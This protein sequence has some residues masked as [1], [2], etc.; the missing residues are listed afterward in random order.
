MC[1]SQSGKSVTEEILPP[2]RM[3][4]LEASAQES[5][6]RRGGGADLGHL[7]PMSATSRN[8]QGSQLMRSAAEGDSALL[9]G[10]DLIVT[11]FEVPVM[12]HSISGG[13]QGVGPCHGLSSEPAG[14]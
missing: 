12:S 5:R 2:S 8:V 1:C 3:A 13:K 9:L 10:G 14:W 6:A 11:V 7:L 4:I